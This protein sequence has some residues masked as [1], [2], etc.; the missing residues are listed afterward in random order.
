MGKKSSKSDPSKTVAGIKRKQP[1]PP[2]DEQLDLAFETARMLGRR[3]PP[4]TRTDDRQQ[5]QGWFPGA[6]TRPSLN[7]AINSIGWHWGPNPEPVIVIEAP[8]GATAVYKRDSLNAERIG[9]VAPSFAAWLGG[10]LDFLRS[11]RGGLPDKWYAERYTM[12]RTWMD[13]TGWVLRA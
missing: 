7:A 8:N 4:Q 3:T 12:L 13:A 10:Q 9:N 5:A 1:P 6:M 11:R 2:R